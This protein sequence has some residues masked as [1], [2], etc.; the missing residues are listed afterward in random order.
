MNEF[1]EIGKKLPYVES[2]EY[3]DSLVERCTQHVVASK[4]VVKR[5]AL[6]K[7]YYAAS[8]VAAAIVIAFLAF[9]FLGRDNDYERISHSQNLDQVLSEM[10]DN[11]AQDISCY[12]VEE[13]PEY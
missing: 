7:W 6:H 2:E 12:S 10:S 1:E 11:Q 3:V 8:A 4:P 9:S 13:V 5:R